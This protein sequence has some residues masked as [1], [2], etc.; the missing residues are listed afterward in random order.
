M[1]SLVAP[2][3][4]H[5]PGFARRSRPLFVAPRKQTRIT[6]NHGS[7]KRVR[8]VELLYDQASQYRDGDL[9]RKPTWKQ[10]RALYLGSSQ[11]GSLTYSN[12]IYETIEKLSA[13]LSDGRPVFM[14]EPNTPADYEMSQFLHPTRP[15]V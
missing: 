11:G 8:F 9:G 10:N 7:D 12:L 2:I 1:S 3:K 6:E 13:D 5:T 4:E 15:V 14:F